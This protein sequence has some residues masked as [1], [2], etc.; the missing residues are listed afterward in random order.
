MVDSILTFYSS[1]AH[2][3]SFSLLG[4]SKDW[5]NEKQALRIRATVEDPMES[6][7]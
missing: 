2:L 7:L 1:N 4:L 6:E 5:K 3:P